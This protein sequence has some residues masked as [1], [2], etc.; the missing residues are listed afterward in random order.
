MYAY[1]SHKAITTGTVQDACIIIL[2]LTD[3]LH[4]TL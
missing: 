3:V 1:L 4:R 2:P